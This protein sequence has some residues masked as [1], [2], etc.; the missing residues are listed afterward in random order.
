M[1]RRPSSTYVK[2]LTLQLLPPQVTSSIVIKRLNKR[3]TTALYLIL[4]LVYNLQRLTKVSKTL[5]KRLY[6]SSHTYLVYK[7]FIAS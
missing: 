6:L 1:L 2:L 4:A 5:S 3:Q 7:P